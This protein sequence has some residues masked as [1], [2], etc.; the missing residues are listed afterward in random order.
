[1]YG[2]PPDYCGL[3]LMPTFLSVFPLSIP[4]YGSHYL[5]YPLPSLGAVL[6]SSLPPVLSDT[7]CLGRLFTA[8]TSKCTFLVAPLENMKLGHLCQLLSSTGKGD[9]LWIQLLF[10][11]AATMFELTA[12]LEF[13]GKKSLVIWQAFESGNQSQEWELFTTVTVAIIDQQ[14]RYCPEFL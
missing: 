10:F 3:P 4:K 14:R 9:P 2:P 8:S 11:W 1:M 6:R 7:Y 12:I 5:F 13:Q